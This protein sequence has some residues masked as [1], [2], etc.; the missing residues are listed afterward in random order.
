MPKKRAAVPPTPKTATKAVAKRRATRRG[1]AGPRGPEPG[2]SALALD[3]PDI[4]PLEARIRAGGGAALAAYRDPYAGSA[5]I[6][7]S[8]P[9]GA[10]EPTPFQRDLSRVHAD[11]LSVAIG[12]VG[13]FLSP[14]GRRQ[15]CLVNQQ[16]QADTIQSRRCH[17]LIVRLPC[18]P[19]RQERSHAS[20]GGTADAARA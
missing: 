19:H 5:V 16:R 1:P 8:L 18:I 11:R 2:D 10:I 14:M 20:W 15:F 13:I 12:A 7:A 3:H 9:L 6:L 17:A 4:A